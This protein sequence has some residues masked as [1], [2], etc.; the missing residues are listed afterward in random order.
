MLS[1]QN[2]SPTPTIQKP[3]NRHGSDARAAIPMDPPGRDGDSPYPKNAEE[4]GRPSHSVHESNPA[5]HLSIE[6]HASQALS[7]QP[8]FTFRPA[9]YLPEIITPPPELAEPP[10][11]PHA[12]YHTGGD[13]AEKKTLYLQQ[14][15]R[16]LCDIVMTRESTEELH[17]FGRKLQV[18][19]EGAASLLFTSG[20]ET[21]YPT[22]NPSGV[23]FHC[24]NRSRSHPRTQLLSNQAGEIGGSASTRGQTG[25]AVTI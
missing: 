8:S 15:L 22:L 17:A 9:D 24:R 2:S 10:I 4:M 16:R 18:A 3:A 1:Q 21:R 7:Q 23:H 6:W 12:Y 20:E 19:L 25:Q 14:Q 11:H 13:A 5:V